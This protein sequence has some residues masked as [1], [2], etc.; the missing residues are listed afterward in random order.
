MP[1]ERKL[2]K[3]MGK[4]GSVYHAQFRANGRLVRKR[5]SGDF[6]TACELLTELKARANRADFGLL[7]NDFQLAEL[8]V[9]WLKHC[10]QTLRPAT[11]TRY[12]ADFKHLKALPVTKVCQ[13]TP[14]VILNYREQRL[15]A[16]R[17]ASPRTVNMEIGT[18]SAMLTWAVKQGMIGS[19]PIAGFKQLP[20]DVKRKQRRA[21]TLAEVEALFRESPEYLKAVWRMFMVTGI[22]RNELVSMRFADIDFERRM[23]TVHGA[24]AKN[25]KARE[26]PLDDDVLAMLQRLKDQAEH[27]KPVVG[28]TAKQ[29]E[30]QAAAFSRDHVFVTKANTPWRN[31]LLT[32]FYSICRKA[33]I[34]GAERKG[35]VDIHAL[36]VSFTTLSI[37]NGASPKAVQAILGHSTL[38]LTMGIYAKATE[39]SKRDAVSALPF[40]RITIP[41]HVLPLDDGSKRNSES[42]V[43]RMRKG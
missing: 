26:I 4:R 6:K 29:T 19:N 15:N 23:V 2:P 25:H 34:A 1:R 11:V 10:E 35:S 43:T 8:R 42:E 12:R 13:I 20:N 22:R 3:G 21:L 31:N 41:N 28:S 27:R 36:R 38:H 5:L 33:G 30:Q 40:A 32:R 9:Q 24:T 18:L 7:D 39:R 16:E 14:A 17:S 37:D